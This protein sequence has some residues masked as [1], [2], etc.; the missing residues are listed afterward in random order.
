MPP[1]CL[2]KGLYCKRVTFKIRKR[3]FLLRVV[4]LDIV[5]SYLHG[6]LKMK[7]ISS[8]MTV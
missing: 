7:E 4:G 6:S 5:L 3:A 2:R 8:K 1:T